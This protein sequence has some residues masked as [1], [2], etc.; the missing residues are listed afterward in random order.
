ML[1]TG[2]TFRF[3]LPSRVTSID[4][5]SI[6][7]ITIR[8]SETMSTGFKTIISVGTGFT[9]YKKKCFQ[10]TPFSCYGSLSNIIVPPK[11]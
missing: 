7:R 2:I 3:R 1:L 4:T 9:F 11:V 6:N 5:T 8:V 10:Y